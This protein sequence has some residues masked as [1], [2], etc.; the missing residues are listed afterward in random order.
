M[1]ARDEILSL[2]RESVVSQEVKNIIIKCI[3]NAYDNLFELPYY[4]TVGEAFEGLP[5][6]R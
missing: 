5:I 4:K 2:R 3:K 1:K 6:L